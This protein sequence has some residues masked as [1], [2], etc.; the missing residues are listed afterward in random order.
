MSPHPLLSR[1]WILKH[2]FALAI[3]L[4]FISLGF[5]QLAR[6]EERRALNAARLA[7]LDD[8][9]VALTGREPDL[10]ALIGRKVRVTGT[11]LNEA[12]VVLRGQRS[13]SGVQ[14]AHLLT[15]LRIAG[16]EAAVIVDRGWIPA[17]RPE[18]AD[19]AAYAVTREVMV[20]GLARAPQARPN[21]PLA[22]RDLPLPGQERINAWVRVDVARL[23]RQVAAPLLPLYIEQFPSGNGATLPRPRD[24]RQLDEGPHLSYAIQ[25]FAFTAI[26]AVVYAALL[27]QQVREAGK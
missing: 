16:S 11:Y 17:P 15:P 6:L 4:S 2:L 14:G 20:E 26:L 1:G 24:P 13:D 7:V 18:A 22:P 10:A 27:R 5:W 25:W 19:L 3:F 21:S 12:S 9:P 8:N 23:Q